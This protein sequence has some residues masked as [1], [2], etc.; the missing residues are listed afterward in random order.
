MEIKAWFQLGVERR[1]TVITIPDEEYRAAE[2]AG[3][4]LESW[5][6]FYAHDW[7]W[8]RIGW[9]WSGGGYSIDFGSMEHSDGTGLCAV[10]DSGIPNTIAMRLD[11]GS[12]PDT[13]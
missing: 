5:L 13:L 2:A 11:A 3:H 7:I 12:G 6:E 10:I 4:L 8:N 1:E 9:G